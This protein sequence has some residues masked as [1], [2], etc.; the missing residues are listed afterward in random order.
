MYNR[1]RN[2]PAFIAFLAALLLALPLAAT[3]GP[4]KQTGPKDKTTLLS[5]ALQVQA[6][7]GDFNTLVAAVLAADPAVQQLLVD[8]GQHTVFAPNDAAF[9]ALGLT[10]DNIGTAFDQDT[11]TTILLYH[12]V[13]GR[14]LAEDVLASDRLNTL[15]RGKQGFVGQS[16]GTLTDNTGGTANIYATD[17]T[18]TN[19]V[20][21]AIDAVLLPFVP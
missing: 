21:H 8:N 1:H 9:G 4:D 13:R 7:T 3:A 6:D 15:L 20:I 5:L 19:G 12:V 14:M 16:G 17:F 11:L 2:A 10:P 18:A